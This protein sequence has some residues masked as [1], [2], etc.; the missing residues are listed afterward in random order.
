MQEFGVL[1]AWI[2]SHWIFGAVGKAKRF[3]DDILKLTVVWYRVVPLVQSGVELSDDLV[4]PSPTH[5]RRREL[6]FLDCILCTFCVN[7]NVVDSNGRR[8]LSS[9]A[10]R[11]ECG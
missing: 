5:E 1:L 10:L 8:S 9:G 11:R 6:R 7:G 2:P 3:E 4:L